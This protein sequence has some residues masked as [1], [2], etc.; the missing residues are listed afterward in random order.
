MS[1]ITYKSVKELEVEEI[2]AKIG[3][4]NEGIV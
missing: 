1:I 2:F 4:N 3:E